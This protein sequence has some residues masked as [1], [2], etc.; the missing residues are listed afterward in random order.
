MPADWRLLCAGP[1]IEI[2]GDDVVV[3]FENGRKHRVRI[4]ET[5]TAF[6]MHAIVAKAAAV[7]D[8]ADLPVRIWRHNRAAQLV[9]FRIDTRG[10][11]YAEGWVPKAGL[12]REE[13]QLVLG[14]VAAESDRFEFLL[15]GR[16]VE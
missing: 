7:R 1:R 5:E 11:V 16:D 13:F 14:R 6:E 12:T 9:G 8:V 10:R 2:D 15:T 4:R 3:G